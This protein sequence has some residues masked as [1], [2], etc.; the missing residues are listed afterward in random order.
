[1]VKIPQIN[2]TRQAM[3]LAWLKQEGIT[4]ASIAKA[5]ETSEQSVSRWMRAE[6]IP[7]WRH[8]QL[9]KFGLPEKLLPKPM[10][11]PSGPKKKM[12]LPTLSHSPCL[13]A[14]PR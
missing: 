6:T 5:L 4:Q 8:E 7:S 14:L 3:L 11:I 13:P 12:V 1:M 10:N 9:V 2:L